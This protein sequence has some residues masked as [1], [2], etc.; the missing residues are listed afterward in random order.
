MTRSNLKDNTC[1]IVEFEPRDVRD[2]LENDEWITVMNKEID[3]IE[4][5]NIQTLI[6]RPKDKKYY[7]N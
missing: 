2:A 7:W 6:P 5:R 1:L 3:Y 4:K